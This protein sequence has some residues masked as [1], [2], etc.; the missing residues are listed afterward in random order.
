LDLLNKIVD[1]STQEWL[2]IKH[3][4]FINK[5]IIFTVKKYCWF[6]LKN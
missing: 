2:E 3:K 1:V 6:N 5:Q 4:S